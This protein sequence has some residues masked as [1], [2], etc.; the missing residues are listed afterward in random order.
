MT[1]ISL[2]SK[3]TEPN[4]PRPLYFVKMFKDG[5]F[6]CQ[7][8]DRQELEHS[9]MELEYIPPPPT[10]EEKIEYALTIEPLKSMMVSEDI[11]RAAAAQIIMNPSFKVPVF[12]PNATRVHDDPEYFFKTPAKPC[13]W[14]WKRGTRDEV[15]AEAEAYRQKMIAS[16]K[17]DMVIKVYEEQYNVVE[18]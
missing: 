10:D 13:I 7:L 18:D 15:I 1:E 5:S 6:T 8:A 11:K 17:W 14:T 9:T 4:D 2:T 16:G 12:D 3:T